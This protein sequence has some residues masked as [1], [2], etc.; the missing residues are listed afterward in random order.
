MDLSAL[1]FCFVQVIAERDLLPENHRPPLV[2][3]ISP[4]LTSAERED[5]AACVCRPHPHRNPDGLIVTNTTLTRP[6]T[7]RSERKR[8]KGGLSGHPL[9]DMSTEAIR[10][11][12]RLTGGNDRFD[13]FTILSFIL[14][15]NHST[16]DF[17]HT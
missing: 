14:Y 15:R 6:A 4:D 5:I 12:Y 10:E 13:P 16:R 17:Q 2:V 11:M 7:L 9:R 3:K 1:T 8:E